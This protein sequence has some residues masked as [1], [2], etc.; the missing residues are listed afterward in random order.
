MK[1]RIRNKLLISFGIVIAL[2]V[3]MGSIYFY[4]SQE[5]REITSENDKLAEGLI[6]IKEKE[7]DHLEWVADLKD[8]FIFGKEFEGELDHTEC[9]FGKWY[10]SLIESDDYQKLPQEI[11]EVLAKIE[12]DHSNLH[13]SAS[14]I[15]N[16]YDTLS[17]VTS[18]V[19]KVAIDIYKNETSKYL[20]QL[21]DLFKEYQDFLHKE[22]TKNMILVQQKKKS[23]D[24]TIMIL[25]ISAIVIATVLALFT[26]KNITAPLAKA[27]EFADKIAHNNL[28]LEEL[29]IESKDELGELA[30]SLNNMYNNLKDMIKELLEIVSSL[31]SYSEE[32]HALAEE[33]DATIESNN[34][35]IERMSASIQE[36]AANTQE[37]TS[38]AEN[39][40]IKTELGSKD[41]EETISS[42]QEINQEVEGTVKTISELDNNSK[43]IEQIVELITNIAKQTNLLALNAAIEAARAGENG[44]G[45]AVVADEIRELA[46]ETSQATENIAELVKETQTKSTVGLE[47]IK[48]V[49]SKVEKGEAVAKKAGKVFKE[50]QESSEETVVHLEQTAASTQSLAENSDD[51]MNV[52]QEIRNMSEEVTTSSQ[53]LAL[54]AQKLQNLTE[55][56]RV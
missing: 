14:K 53:D 45:F 1:L 25:I 36:I 51:I 54:M 41:I 19:N 22:T 30:N 8:V 52:S 10:Y 16:Q 9:S 47:A 28:N 40:S 43:E 48:R 29:D 37:V 4:L 7:I 12:E 20:T 50:L 15:K 39:S 49:E 11:K 46:E 56:F 42:L 18:D 5:I 2:M 26:S 27:V 3:I 17:T 38:F 31:S 55:K 24:L 23:I 21:Q 6:F 44:Q 33:S 32:L 13:H 34:Q 35:L